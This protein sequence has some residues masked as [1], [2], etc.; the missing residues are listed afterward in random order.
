MHAI[1]QKAFDVLD[2]YVGSLNGNQ[3]EKQPEE[4]MPDRIITNL[5]QSGK[6]TLDFSGH[7]TQKR[8]D[9]TKNAREGI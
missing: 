5:S 2:A 1:T 4:T 6:N 7:T 9:I 3:D 8:A